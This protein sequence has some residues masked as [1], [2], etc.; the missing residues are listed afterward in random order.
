M[1]SDLEGSLQLDGRVKH[2][3]GKPDVGVGAGEL[4]EDRI[5]VTP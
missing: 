5:R 3:S 4:E 2:T 1:G